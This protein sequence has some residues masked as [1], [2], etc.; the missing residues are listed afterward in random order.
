MIYQP[1]QHLRQPRL[2]GPNAE[3]CELWTGIYSLWWYFLLPLEVTLETYHQLNHTSWQDIFKCIFIIGSRI[4]DEGFNVDGTFPGN[5]TQLNTS[6]VWKN[7]S[8]HY[9]WTIKSYCIWSNTS[10]NIWLGFNVCI[11]IDTTKTYYVGVSVITILRL[12]MVN[13]YL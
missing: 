2:H 5:Y 6:G 13:L 10:N 1:L 12:K 11:D 3:T 7:D 4:Y 9:I 8:I